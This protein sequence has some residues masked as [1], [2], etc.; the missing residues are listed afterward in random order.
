MFNN[1]NV[2]N[3]NPV[4]KKKWNLTEQGPISGSDADTNVNI[5]Q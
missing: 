2:I 4:E 5:N 1:R 3:P